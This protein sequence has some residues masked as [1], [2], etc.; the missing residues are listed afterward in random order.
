MPS[1]SSV[2]R[3]S[4]I[5]STEIK[6]PALFSRCEIVLTAVS[7]MLVTKYN[8]SSISQSLVF[9]RLSYSEVSGIFMCL[10]WFYQIIIGIPIFPFFD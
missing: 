3:P 7:S 9:A 10:W 5:L 2:F 6:Y 4:W 8:P 1:M